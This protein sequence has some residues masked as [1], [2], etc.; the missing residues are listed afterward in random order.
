[1]RVWNWPVL[2]VIP[3]VM[4]LV[5]LLIRIDMLYSLRCLFR[6]GDDGGRGFG[7]GVGA[8]DGQARGRQHLLA[9]FFVG[10]LHAHDQRHAEV[11]GLAG[12]DDAFGDHVAA[13]D[14]AEDVDQDGLDAVVPEH[15]LEGFGDLFGRG[16]TADVQEV[17]RLAA[18]QLDGIH[19]GHGQAGAVDQAADVAVELDV[20]QIELAGLDFGGI[21]FIQ[22]A[23]GNDFGMAEQRIGIEVELRVQ[24]ND[25]ALAVAVQGVDFNQRGI[26]FHV[27][28]I[29]LL[30]YVDELRHG[31]GRHGDALGQR[32][33]VGLGEALQGVDLHGDDLLGRRMRDFLDVHAA[34]TGG[35]EGH[36]LRGA[37]GHDGQVVFLLD[38]GAFL[39][40][41]AANLL[42]FGAGL[43][44]DQLH[45]QNL[46]GQGP[47]FVEGLGDLHAAALAPP[48]GVDL[49]LD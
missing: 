15:D 27:A 20:R 16:A 31:V 39:D 22:V 23:V 42:A 33:A 18:E 12:G 47:D 3:W 24:G 5:S 46:A 41:Q 7:H 19:G 32:V 45:A 25:V 21:L 10:A 34:F 43:V 11:H 9:L 30:A 6:G 35:D 8:D 37:I 1:M 17:G 28:R 2:P 13:H 29:E 40:V 26:G 4:T 14:A 49:R 48:A 38:I 44:R 36:F